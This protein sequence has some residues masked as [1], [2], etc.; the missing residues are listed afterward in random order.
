MNILRI[1]ASSRTEQSS[2]RSLADTLLKKIITDHPEASL[3][4]RDII[5]HPIPHIN[6]KTIKGFYTPDDQF[7]DTLRGA[8]KQSDILI[9]ELKRADILVISSPMYNFGTPSALKAWVDQ[10]VRINQT[11]GV[12]EDNSFYGMLNNIKTYIIT[13]AGAVYSNDQMKSYDFLTPYLKTVLGLIGITD[14]TVLPLEGTTLAP[15]IFER[16]KKEALTI[17]KNL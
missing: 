12:A 3:I 15:D 13:S 6:Q 16:T 1:D 7:T 10:I 14:I 2:S 5:K 8:T 17:I 4:I 9:R 11:F